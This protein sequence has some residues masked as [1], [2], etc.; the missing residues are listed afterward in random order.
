MSDQTSST[1]TA[2]APTA[3]TGRTVIDAALADG[4]FTTLATALTAAGLVE[5][6]KGPGPFTVFAP[7]DDA[8]KA[9]P[10]GMLDG[11]LK[12]LAKL[13]SVLTFHVVPG[14]LNA[15]DLKA[16]VDKDGKASAKTVEGHM[17][18]VQID[19]DGVRVA[20]EN[21]VTVTTADVGASNGVIHVIDGVLLPS[22]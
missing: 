21:T 6:L 16:L 22:K 14:R 11:L 7:T 15:V 5:T 1:A 17:L 9:L 10:A 18:G 4:R 3:T 20:G 8:F 2:P 12:D 13:T 19:K